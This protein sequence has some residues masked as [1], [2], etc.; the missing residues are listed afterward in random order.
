[1]FGVVIG[2]SR[3]RDNSIGRLQFSSRDA[4]RVYRVF[5]TQGLTLVIDGHATKQTLKD[6]LAQTRDNAI[7]ASKDRSA[8][9]LVYFSGHESDASIYVHDSVGHEPGLTFAE[10][11]DFF[12]S[13]H[14]AQV[15]TFLIVDA[16]RRVPVPVGGSGS[17][18]AISDDVTVIADNSFAVIDKNTTV[19]AACSQGADAFESESLRESAMTHF[20]LNRLES[21]GRPATLAEIFTETRHE[22]DQFF[23]EFGRPPPQI[24]FQA[25]PQANLLL[26]H[27][28]IKPAKMEPVC[29]RVN[30]D[31]RQYHPSPVP[32]YYERQTSFHHALKA[33]LLAD[34]RLFFVTGEKLSGKSMTLSAV[35]AE[36]KDKDP[37][38]APE[39]VV[40]INC[41]R[42]I[43]F[44][45]LI[46]FLALRLLNTAG[47]KR[48]FQLCNALRPSKVEGAEILAQEAA[49][50][51]AETQATVVFDHAGRL[52]L[53]SDVVFQQFLKILNPMGS[54]RVILVSDQPPPAVVAQLRPQ[55]IRSKYN[56][57]DSKHFLPA[58]LQKPE[59]IICGT[60]F[61]LRALK[62]LYE[63]AYGL[64]ELSREQN[65]TDIDLIVNLC[66]A[67]P[68]DAR[69]L[70][71]HLVVFD[72]SR[73]EDV[74]DHCVTMANCEDKSACIRALV[75]A[76]L[77]VKDAVRNDYT[78]H[79]MVKQHLRVEIENAQ[80]VDRHQ[81]AAQ[82]YR[83]RLRSGGFS[84]GDLR[85]VWY[86]WE[87]AGDF[88][89]LL[90]LLRKY[91]G[92]LLSA[93]H[94][95]IAR[96]RIDALLKR[97]ME[98]RIE[99]GFLEFK[100]RL[101]RHCR[102][103]EGLD[104]AIVGL[105]VIAE[106]STTE[107]EKSR[108]QAKVQL[109]EGEKQLLRREYEKAGRDFQDT[110]QLAR[111]QN[112]D[113]E[114]VH[115]A[116]R[117]AQVLHHQGRFD[118]SLLWLDHCEETVKATDQP[119]AWRSRNQSKIEGRR[120]AIYLDLELFDKAKHHAEQSLAH[121]KSRDDGPGNDSLGE[122]IA[123][124]YLAEALIGLGQRH[125]LRI[126]DDARKSLERR[127]LPEPWWLTRVHRCLSEAWLCANDVEEA[128]CEIELGLT[129][130]EGPVERDKW[131]EAELL[132][133][134][135]RVHDAKGELEEALKLLGRAETLADKQL[136]YPELV[137]IRHHRGEL[138]ARQDQVDSAMDQFKSA[139]L[140]A[141]KLGL[142][143]PAAR[144][145]WELAKLHD[146]RHELGDAFWTIQKA[147]EFTARAGASIPG[148]L[149]HAEHFGDA[150][151]FDSPPTWLEDLRW[152][153]QRRRFVR[154]PFH[155]PG[156][157]SIDG[158]ESIPIMTN[159]VS[160]GGLCC[161][162]TKPIGENTLVR[163][164]LEPRPGEVLP[165]GSCVVR[166][167]FKHDKTELFG[168]SYQ[169]GASLFILNHDVPTQ[170]NQSRNT[171]FKG[172]GM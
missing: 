130:I 11:N 21:E 112:M 63:H 125:A 84:F 17:E 94:A 93:G 46:P 92:E 166:R 20:F 89:Q 162:A 75:D 172:F 149:H 27:V 146:R 54:G 45:D 132:L 100:Q 118:A 87:Q 73:S 64:F 115:A 171:L 120:A 23:K 114:A 51:I 24:H 160:I 43:V 168:S 19:L 33:K 161:A 12:I 6:I 108:L 131:R 134:K 154:F 25:G 135:A 5:S 58:E 9:V 159:D 53:E 147:I 2:V 97:D 117:L 157:I 44:R 56:R 98:K 14:Q 62:Y 143:V 47:S 86:H 156:K 137:R 88:P 101:A 82:F 8:S 150:P 126:A 116:F 106:L 142:D 4:R 3:C 15:A 81:Q 57:E 72:V 110:I 91:W 155:W 28:P 34:C 105:K 136:H 85:H 122:S 77:L 42:D 55:S 124:I 60:P 107:P 104:Q 41:H 32:Q 22:H 163:V 119:P 152:L 141:S 18:N 153:R 139:A 170:E 31:P 52:N 50:A 103:F 113:D 66:K 144:S 49:R 96:R 140:L 65:L 111:A 71:G 13:L 127:A 145:L 128:M 138:L 61:R 36:L 121:A 78:I 151:V 109:C 80:D 76:S 102:D 59:S 148:L 165:F 167:S 74:I 169:H 37:Q 129:W 133:T 35:I 99:F 48:L 164:E 123:Q 69:R 1:L 158:A 40:W 30:E 95:T 90:Q 16:C 83:N 39:P 7:K 29:D 70:L 79:H 38:W 68:K 67:L 26:K 10:L